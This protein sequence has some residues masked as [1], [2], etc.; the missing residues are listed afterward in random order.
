MEGLH[1]YSPLNPQCAAVDP[2][3]DRRCERYAVHVTSS[4][5]V[6][7]L[8]GNYEPGDVLTWGSVADVRQAR[9]EGAAF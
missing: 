9:A 7:R 8:H 3:W 6:D 1:G 2:I 5:A 4:A